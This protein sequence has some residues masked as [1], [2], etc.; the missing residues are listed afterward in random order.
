LSASGQRNNF[1]ATAGIAQLVEHNLAK[2][3]VA[4][5]SPVSRFIVCR[6][7]RSMT[8]TASRVE[9]RIPDITAL[10]ARRSRCANISEIAES[11]H[12]ARSDARAWARGRTRVAKW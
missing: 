2:V 6:L 7:F 9:E 3:G 4:G 11:L 10:A 1:V 12:I 8:D 5:S